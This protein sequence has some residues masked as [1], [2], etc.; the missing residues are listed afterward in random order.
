VVVPA[1]EI[2]EVELTD[3]LASQQTTPVTWGNVVLSMFTD[4][5]L[6][7]VVAVTGK[8]TDRCD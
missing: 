8:K 7:R 2:I 4:D 3:S 5:L 6:A 1:N